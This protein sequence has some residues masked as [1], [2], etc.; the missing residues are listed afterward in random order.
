MKTILLR[1]NRNRDRDDHRPTLVTQ[2]L[3]IFQKQSRS[4]VLLMAE[5]EA[6]DIR[7]R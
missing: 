4:V 1:V 5:Y 7:R 3:R 2:A 6:A